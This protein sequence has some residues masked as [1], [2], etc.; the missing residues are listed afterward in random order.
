MKIYSAAMVSALL[1]TLS[2][3]K[4]MAL[5]GK[6]FSNEGFKKSFVGSYG[7][8]PQVEPKVDSEEN[9]ILADMTPLFDTGRFKEAERQLA[10]FVRQRQQPGLEGE[11]AKGISPAMIFVLGNLYYQNGRVSEAEQS[12]RLAIRS[13]PKFRRAHKNLAIL[14]ADKERFQDALPHLQQAIELGDADQ[15]SYGLL[16]YIYLNDENPISAEIAYR[17]ALLLAPKE[18]DWRYGLAQCLVAQEKWVESVSFLNLLIREDYG[19]PALWRQQANVYLSMDKRMEAAKNFEVL[20]NMKKLT[21]E[22]LHVLGNIYVDQE[23]PFLALGAYLE[24]INNSKS[25]NVERSLEAARIMV[26][27]GTADKATKLLEALDSKTRKKMT[28]GQE[29]KFLLVLS[30]TSREAGKNAAAESYLNDVL[31]IDAVN[32]KALVEYGLL[33]EVLANE[34]TDEQEQIVLFTEAAA[35][36]RS[37]LHIKEVEYDAN[38]RYGQMQV[39]RNAFISAMPF[40]VKAESLKPSDNLNL[41]V[42][43]VR[44]AAAREKEVEERLKAEMEANKKS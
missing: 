19:N 35:K 36:F 31:R 16:G 33:L 27:Y 40:L 25:V 15:R 41:Y 21:D 39:R 4:P 8:L 1:V 26:D 3:A 28:K 18:R 7:F 2:H 24:A 20:R 17:Q 22:E 14:L 13:F 6:H 42:R 5:T 23:E 29:A 9:Q 32:G 44:R 11:K 12:Y 10:G 34:E 38:L 30:K 43:R 37:A